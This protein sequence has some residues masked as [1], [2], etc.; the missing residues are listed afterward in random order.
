MKAN[1]IYFVIV[2]TIII[3]VLLFTFTFVKNEDDINLKPQTKNEKVNSSKHYSINKLD[4]GE[5]VVYKDKYCLCC[6]LWAEKFKEKGYSVKEVEVKDMAKIKSEKG[7]PLELVSCHT[8]VLDGKY[9][10]EGHVPIES[11]LKLQKENP[12][13]AGLAVPGMPTGVPGMPGRA[14]FDTL[15]IY[16]FNKDGKQSIFEER[17]AGE[18]EW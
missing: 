17:G 11:V 16:S 18:I 1:K 4:K 13:I 10:L 12:D 14:S 6:G 9:I 8:A 15:Q 2:I 5:I 7:V 3:L